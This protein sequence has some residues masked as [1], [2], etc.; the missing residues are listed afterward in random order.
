[1][2]L[3]LY[4][5][6]AASLLAAM[7]RWVRPMSRSAMLVLLAIPCVVTAYALFSGRAFGPVDM[8]YNTVPLSWMK[9]QYG[10]SGDAHN[11]SLSDLYCQMIPWRKAVQWSIAHGEWPLWNR[12]ILSGDILAAAAQPAAYSPLTLIAILMPVATSFTFSAAIAFFLAALGAFLFARELGCR[13]LAALTGAAA[14]TYSSGL[15]F[16]ILWP[17][18]VSWALLPL[19]LVA[20]RHIVRHPGVPTFAL[21]TA[22]FTLLL[23]SGHPETALHVVAIGAVYGLFELMRNARA[24]GVTLSTGLRS[25]ASKRAITGAVVAGIVALLLCAIYLL[26]VLD[27]APQT[28]EHR[29]RSTI[30]VDQPR[31]SHPPEVLARI[32]TGFFVWLHGRN[33]TAGNVNVPVESFAVGSIAMALALY[34]LWRVRSADARFLAGL[35]LFGIVAASEWSPLARLLQ[36]LPLFDISLNN[37]FA[38]GAAFALAMLAGLGVEELCRRER[39]RAAAII[40]AATLIV[41]GAGTWLLMRANVV[42]PAPPEW[43]RHRVAAEVGMLAAGT[44]VLTFIRRARPAAVALLGLL[45]AQRYVSDGDVYA[46]FPARAAYPPVAIFAP[47]RTPQ[48]PFRIV[49]HHTALIPGTN[50]LYE[51]EDVRGYEAMTFGPYADTYRIWCVAQPVWFNRV[52]DLQEAFLSFLNVRYAITSDQEPPRAGWR[53]VARQK[54]SVLLQ[55]ERALERAFVP[56]HVSLGGPSWLAVNEMSSERDFAQRA[57]IRGEPDRVERVNGPGRVTSI[58]DAKLGYDLDVEM[59]KDGWVATSISDWKGWRAYIDGRRVETTR[60]NAAFVGVYVPPG[61]HHV[62]LL[63]WPRSFVIG[64]AITLATLLSLIAFAIY[65]VIVRRRGGTGMPASAVV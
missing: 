12:F 10:L 65:R 35:A 54:G 36:Q 21:L 39:D 38:F 5:A 3:I 50:A 20:T 1:M 49:G 4:L 7:H 22:V 19:V 61:R 56:R 57:W 63:Y 34:A 43:G 6:T 58:R 14:W 45:L 27:A 11:G 9:E 30:F 29:F 23:L 2:A 24:G 16:F 44:L 31:G 28:N 18:G 25:Q 8:P 32:A 46:S 59:E 26:P 47:T 48:T 41:L 60:A 37:R 64:R 53:E 40:F 62:R 42:D 17:L 15:A 51:L 13:E 55:N 52:D 33:W